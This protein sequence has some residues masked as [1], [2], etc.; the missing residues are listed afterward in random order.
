[1]INFN[2]DWSNRNFYKQ[3]LQLLNDNIKKD[4]RGFNTMK[5]LRTIIAILAI[6]LMLA[7]SVSANSAPVI[8]STAITAAVEDETYTYDVE[9]TDSDMGD[10]LTF[11]LTASPDDMTI[12]SATGVIT[13]T[14]NEDQIGSHTVT[15]KVADNGAPQASTEQTFTIFARPKSVCGN[16]VSGSDIRITDVNIENDNQNEEDFYPGDTINIQVDTENKGN[17]KIEDIVVKTILYDT[18]DGKIIDSSKS[19]RFN[20]Q[21]GDSETSELT[22]EV[23]KDIIIDNDMILF[24]SAYEDGNDDQNCHWEYDDSLDFKRRKHDIAI[25][26]ATLTPETVKAGKTVEAKIYVE[27]VG[28]RDEE[29]SYI[30]IKNSELKIDKKSELFNTDSYEN[31]NDDEYTATVTFTVPVDTKADEYDLE[32]YVYDENN[33]IYES[34]KKFVTLTVEAATPAAQPSTTGTATIAVKEIS[35]TLEPGKAYSIPVEL[36]NKASEAKE[37]K[38]ML[39]NIED[40]AGSTS[41]IDAYLIQGQTSTYYLTI[42]PKADATGGKHS[43]TVTIK[44]G[45]AVLTT[46]TLSFTIPEKQ[47]SSV[48]GGT[49]LDVKTED[50]TIF[51]N[52][53]SGTTFWMIGDLVL[54]LVAVFFIRMLFSKKEE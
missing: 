29:N 13:W 19:D 23:P 33:N 14:P 36:T 26:E 5:R 21:E 8:T 18:T 20:L 10:V 15:V 37:Y 48:T 25:N 51:Q 40:W 46:K 32:I 47:V 39:T 2:S 16:Y 30:K 31:G 42:V 54:V 34:G 27:N 6:I 24:T 4:F 12:N 35:E 7:V 1:M 52:L 17:D 28:D 9:A 3:I 45:T 22:L 41:V 44:E 38:I 11:S 53:F 49:V 50:K 43:A